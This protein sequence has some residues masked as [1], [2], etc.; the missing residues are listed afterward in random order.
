MV[1]NSLLIALISYVLT[2]I[3][4]LLMQRNLESVFFQAI[5]LMGLIFLTALFLQLAIY[6][7]RDFRDEDSA[8]ETAET[9][10]KQS[11]N[12]ASSDSSHQEEEPNEAKT[13]AD[14][15]AE[16]EADD[17]AEIEN[18]FEA[19]DSGSFSALNPEELDY[20]E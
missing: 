19:A 5:R 4:N 3:Y 16:M 7:I 14:Y 13:V 20:Q 17:Q 9:K 15:E 8:S 10:S 18:E 6:L 1:F 12:T 2:I 11:G